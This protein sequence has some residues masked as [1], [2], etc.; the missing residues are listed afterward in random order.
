MTSSLSK[1]IAK[2]LDENL[3][4]EAVICSLAYIKRKPMDFEARRLLIDLLIVDGDYERADKQADILSNTVEDFALGMGL[5][6]GRLQAA[7]ARKNWF[8]KGEV[9]AFPQGPTRRD[10]QAMRLWTDFLTKDEKAVEESLEKLSRI[11][12]THNLFVNRKKAATFRDAD[13]RISHALEILC[14]DGN[15]MWVDFDLVSKIEFYPINS[16]RDLVWRGAKLTLKGGSQSDVV[17]CTTYF[18]D[19]T[20]NSAKLARETDWM[21]LMAGMVTGIGQK[22]FVNDDDVIEAL[23]LKT[24]T[25]SVK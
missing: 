8:L 5:L 13:D 2:L 14:T 15:Y 21:T 1:E 20:T 10:K 7:S 9:P 24:L 22:I 3:L 23:A 16:V 19:D 4:G 17:V 25:E 12:E 18:A 11:S 6:R